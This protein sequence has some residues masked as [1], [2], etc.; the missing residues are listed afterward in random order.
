MVALQRQHQRSSYSDRAAV[1][2][3]AQKIARDRQRKAEATS[4]NALHVRLTTGKLCRVGSVPEVLLQDG[5]A[6]RE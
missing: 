2:D 5:E 6:D 1:D 3:I 4:D